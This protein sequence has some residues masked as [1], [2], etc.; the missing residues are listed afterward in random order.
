MSDNFTDLTRQCAV[1]AM[2]QLG[3]SSA[4]FWSATPAE[5]M[6]AL[7]PVNGGEAPPTRSQIEDMMERDRN[8]R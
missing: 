7:G 8:G 6:L 4:E 2:Q 5:L 1:V 3:W